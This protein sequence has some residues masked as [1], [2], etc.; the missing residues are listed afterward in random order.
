M[1]SLSQVSGETRSGAAVE[2]MSWT[3]AVEFCS[4]LRALTGKN[5]RLPSEAEWEYAARAG[6][7]AAYSFGPS[8]TNSLV[9]WRTQKDA[10]DGRYGVEEVGE[11]GSA[12]AFGL[13]DVQGNVEEWVA[14]D[15]HETYVGAP[16]DGSAWYFKKRPSTRKDGVSRGGAW[17]D[18]TIEQLRCAS[19]AH[20]DRRLRASGLG[21]RV[22]MSPDD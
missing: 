5:Y 15:Y 19:R 21:M 2:G 14:D 6:S 7:D 1:E 3:D 8:V 12:N 16:A 4:R 20:W 10:L 22:A 9:N 18:G 17:G 13:F 11:S